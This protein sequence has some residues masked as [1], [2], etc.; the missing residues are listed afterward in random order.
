MGERC[1]RQSFERSNP[2]LRYA[3]DTFYQAEPQPTA[4]QNTALP[5]FDR[6][7]PSRG[8]GW[9]TNERPC[10]LCYITRTL[11]PLPFLLSVSVDDSGCA[12]DCA[13]GFLTTKPL[14]SFL[15]SPLIACCASLVSDSFH[16]RL[17]EGK[18][19]M[20]PC[21]SNNTSYAQY[22]TAILELWLLSRSR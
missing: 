3:D 21:S 4:H 16:A 12:T 7:G 9:Q 6:N 13:K 8:A 17:I 15:W 20:L 18:Q 19:G 2:S 1:T 14:T 22:S 10:A 11:K 5:P